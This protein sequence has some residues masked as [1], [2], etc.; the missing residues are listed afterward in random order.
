M[1]FLYVLIPST[2]SK[3]I[4]SRDPLQVARLSKLLHYLTLEIHHAVMIEYSES[5]QSWFLNLQSP[6]S[7]VTLNTSSRSTDLQ[8]TSNRGSHS[9]RLNAIHSRALNTQAAEDVVVGTWMRCDQRADYGYSF[10]DHLQRMISSE[11]STSRCVIWPCTRHFV[12]RGQGPG[13][14]LPNGTFTPH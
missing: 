1:R 4:G 11:F 8:F 2:R 7:W 12:K 13:N 3:E 9:R 5:T 6:S 10:V 14:H